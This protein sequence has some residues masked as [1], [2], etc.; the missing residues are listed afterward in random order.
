[1][2]SWIHRCGFMQFM[3][4][5]LKSFI[6]LKKIMSNRQKTQTKNYYVN[7]N[8][9]NYIKNSLMKNEVD[10]DHIYISFVL[11]N[12]NISNFPEDFDLDNFAS[13][14]IQTVLFDIVKYDYLYIFQM[15]VQKV[16]MNINYTI[17]LIHVFFDAIQIILFF[18]KFIFLIFF[19]Q[20]A[21][22]SFS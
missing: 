21:F 20:F 3:E 18:T 5:R 13:K 19:I 15:I 14:Y 10:E 7:N 6:F 4:I 11:K 16:N 1:M 9:T 22:D 2:L 8:I 17:I 12:R